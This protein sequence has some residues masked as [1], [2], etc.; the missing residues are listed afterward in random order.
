MYWKF[1]I[2]KSSKIYLFYFIKTDKYDQI[3]NYMLENS[4]AIRKFNGYLR[5]TAGTDEENRILMEVM[6]KCVQQ[7]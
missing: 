2:N 5:I 7:L 3:Y 6:E 4:I 1:L